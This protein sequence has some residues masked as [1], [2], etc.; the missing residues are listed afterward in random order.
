[1][2]SGS[3]RRT[4]DGSVRQLA[5]VES[6]EDDGRATGGGA[7]AAA[8]DGGGGRSLRPRDR[9]GEAMGEAAVPVA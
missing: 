1:M 8:R 2:Q 6:A 7:A 5:A 3:R 9:L 4:V